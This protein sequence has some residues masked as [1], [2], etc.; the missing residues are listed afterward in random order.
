ML[1]VLG[2]YMHNEPYI[3]SY[4]YCHSEHTVIKRSADKLKVTHANVTDQSKTHL[5]SL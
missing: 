2:S 5:S 3:M 4:M 1:R